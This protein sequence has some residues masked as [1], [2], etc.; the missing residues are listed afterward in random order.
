VAE[1][2]IGLAAWLQRQSEQ[3]RACAEMDAEE[4]GMRVTLET[5][6]RLAQASRVVE[7][8]AVNARGERTTQKRRPIEANEA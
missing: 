5:A 7:E 4:Y 2:L 3:A 6:V 8:A 1:D